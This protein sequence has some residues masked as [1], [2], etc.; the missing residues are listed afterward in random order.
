[1][2][3][4]SGFCGG[5]SVATPV[6]LTAAANRAAAMVRSLPIG[7][8]WFLAC[9]VDA[10]GVCAAAVAALA[11][12]R[13]GYR[14]QARASREKTRE[15]YAALREVECDGYI[16]LDKG[17][18]HLDALQ[19][20]STITGRPVIVLDHHNLPEPMP[21]LERVVLVNPR[22]EGMDGSR[23]A[24]AATVS[25]AFALALGGDGNL[26][27]G[28]VGLAGAIGDWQH[29]GGWQG[30]NKD[31]LDRCRDAGHVTE[32]VVPAF[33]GIDLAEA[34]GRKRPEWSRFHGDREHA[35]GLLTG[36]G[37]DPSVE[38]EELTADQK[39]ALLDALVLDTLAAG[40]EPHAAGLVWPVDVDARLGI[41][42]RHLFRV[43]DACGRRGDAA[44]GL[45]F[46]FGSS[47]A[48][49][50]A[51]KQFHSYKSDLVAAIEQLRAGGADVRRALQWVWTKKPELTGMVGGLGMT[52]F[53]Q[54]RTRPMLITAKRGNGEVQVSTRGT[55]EQVEAGLNLG[56]AVAIAAS[57]V[58][59]EGG[60]HPIAAGTVVLESEME[61]FV[62]ALDDA[63][64]QQGFLEAS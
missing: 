21:K 47:S 64:M 25:A 50:G 56:H 60:G 4:P 53:V 30:W 35:A 16:V 26:D 19:K 45:A 33:V 12:Q 36:L 58:G 48:R 55:H 24:S 32:D 9:D 57:K 13:A 22:A 46:L 7:S 62:A 1:M 14:F 20:V 6:P 2:P 39:T 51:M 23:D 15:A 61:P 5:P 42:L 3:D 41:G 44:T 17:T 29:E 31:L 27:L 59:R 52:H 11:L 43:V 63:L 10:D 49:A 8:R 38:A 37:I 18:S 54:D 40:H 28:P 34:L